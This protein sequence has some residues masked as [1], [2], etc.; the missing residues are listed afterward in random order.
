MND[1]NWSPASIFRY[2][3]SNADET[4]LSKKDR[5]NLEIIT[6][7]H[8]IFLH[9]RF[10]KK[11]GKS[12]H[13]IGKWKHDANSYEDLLD[14]I[15]KIIPHVATGEFPVVKFTNYPNVFSGE[16]TIVIYCFPDCLNPVETRKILER[17]TGIYVYWG[18]KHYK[19]RND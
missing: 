13:H 5:G 1:N 6:D 18:S 3:E 15:L 8:W 2:L 11:S 17:E 7:I 19:E 12:K 16:K 4:I 9:S 10:H 14:K